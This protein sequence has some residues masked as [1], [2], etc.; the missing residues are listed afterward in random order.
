[1]SGKQIRKRWNVG[2]TS[3][4]RSLTRKLKIYIYETLSLM[5]NIFL[6]AEFI[7]SVEGISCLVVRALGV[8]QEVPDPNPNLCMNLCSGDS[9]LNAGPDLFSYVV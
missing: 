7:L 6:L 8:R 3:K 1:M 5:C 2:N 9:T 4:R